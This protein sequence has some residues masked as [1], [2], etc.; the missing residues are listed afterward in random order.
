[1]SRESCAVYLC[2]LCCLFGWHRLRWTR[3]VVR[4]SR[5]SHALIEVMLELGRR[6]GVCFSTETTTKRGEMMIFAQLHVVIIMLMSKRCTA[7]NGRLAKR[8]ASGRG[9]FVAYEGDAR[10]LWSCRCI[11]QLLGGSILHI[12]HESFVDRGTIASVSRALTSS[13]GSRTDNRGLL[14]CTLV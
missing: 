2:C 6:C 7:P 5:A 1:M 14:C 4:L 12:C 8:G 3:R 10:Q 9:R 11:P 13:V